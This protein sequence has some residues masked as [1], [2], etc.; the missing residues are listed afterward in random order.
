MTIGVKRQVLSCAGV[1]AINVVIRSPVVIPIL[2]KVL[3]QGV[4]F[5]LRVEHLGGVGGVV[6]IDICGIE[7][8]YS[9][10]LFVS[11]QIQHK[12]QIV[13]SLGGNIGGLQLQI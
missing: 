4:F 1:G 13:G 2:H 10:N 11:I 3:G 12:I 9:G 6:G 5:A 8:R 7:R